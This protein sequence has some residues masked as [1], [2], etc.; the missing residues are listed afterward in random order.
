MKG[1]FVKLLCIAG[2]WVAGSV[3]IGHPVAGVLTA[4]F[5]WIAGRAMELYESYREV[6]ACRPESEKM[7]EEEYLRRM[8]EWDEFRKREEEDELN[9][10]D[11]ASGILDLDKIFP[12]HS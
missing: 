11:I 3:M 5:G 1:A 4:P 10:D 12:S 8:R 2:A 9:F 6:P 7:E